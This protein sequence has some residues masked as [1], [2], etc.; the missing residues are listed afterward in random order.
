MVVAVWVA[1]NII[2]LTHFDVYPFILLNR[3]RT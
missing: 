1:V 3:K 2:G